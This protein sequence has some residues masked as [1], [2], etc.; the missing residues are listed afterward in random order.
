MSEGGIDDLDPA[1]LTS[2]ATFHQQLASQPSSSPS[3]SSPY[4]DC[5]S[6]GPT[7][8]H[9]ASKRGDS[10][11][12]RHLHSLYMAATAASSS[13]SSSSLSTSATALP[14][15]ATGSR[16]DGG[17]SASETTRSPTGGTLPAFESCDRQGRTPLMV[18]CSS[19]GATECVATLLE[20]GCGA[21][22]TAVTEQRGSI[23]GRRTPLHL[24]AHQGGPATVQLLLDWAERGRQGEVKPHAAARGPVHGEQLAR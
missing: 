2:E 11:M 21:S 16:D 24:A 19:S 20:W 1:S 7:V 5:F 12:L 22:A 23:R 9:L 15:S 14:R 3:S 8:W 13:S 10:A 6:S 18:A 17:P 4:S